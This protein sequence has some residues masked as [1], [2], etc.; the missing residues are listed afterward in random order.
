ME[1]F[2]N[3]S[4]TLL[5]NGIPLI[6]RPFAK[7]ADELRSTEE[8]LLLIASKLQVDGVIREIAPIFEASTLGYRSTLIAC[9]ADKSLIE[10]T[11]GFINS[12]PCVSHNYEREGE[13][14]LWF[15]LTLP[16]CVSID[17]TL[18]VFEGLQG[19]NRLLKLEKE[20]MYKIRVAFKLDSSVE[21]KIRE[22]KRPARKPE[23]DKKELIKM[24]RVLQEGLPLRS[25]P[26]YI[27]ANR[28][29]MK[30]DDFLKKVNELFD[31][32]VIR[33][34]PAM[35]RHK[36]IGIKSNALIVFNIPEEKCDETGQSFASEGFVTHCYKRKTYKEWPYN[37]YAMIHARDEE[38]INGYIEELK[39]K[40][41]K[42]GISRT[43]RLTF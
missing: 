27:L 40:T 32:G 18:N 3:K 13:F 21:K 20:T 38:T 17:K 34:F 30:E 10:K 29:G 2:I 35:L 23:M 9:E 4:L 19:I 22:E 14:N 11:S 24:V 7:L 33:R 15:T 25:D 39:G 28:A 42:N 5:Q 31:C 8:D 41:S 26:F 16:E 6:R 37:L 1:E 12:H 43:F 36:K